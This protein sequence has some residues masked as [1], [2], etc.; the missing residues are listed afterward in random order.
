M[1]AVKRTILDTACDIFN[2]QGFVNTRIAHIAEAVGISSGNLAYHFKNTHEILAAVFSELK[3]KQVAILSDILLTPLFQNFNRYLS[4]SFQLQH[5]YLFF[6]AEMLPL[7][8]I[9]STITGDYQQHIRW[10]EIQFELLLQAYQA[11]GAFRADL[12]AES[13]SQLAILLRRSIDSWWMSRLTEGKE[14]NGAEDFCD[15]I[16]GI[17]QPYFSDSGLKEYQGMAPLKESS[18]SSPTEI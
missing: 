8:R 9:S 4:E 16:W 7:M 11:R 12:P 17:F 15:D 3:E 18:L 13:F 10:Q 1:K 2:Q 14:M 5:R 6:Y